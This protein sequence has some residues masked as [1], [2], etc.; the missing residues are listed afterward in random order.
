MKKI[1]GLDIGT[2]S[3]GLAVIEEAENENEASKILLLASRIIPT[4]SEDSSL[5]EFNTGKPI[6]KNRVKGEDRSKRRNF[7][8]LKLG[9]KNLIKDLLEMGIWENADIAIGMQNQKY[10]NL[11]N[12]LV[13]Q[14]F[15]V[16]SESSYQKIEKEDFKIL[17]LVFYN[18][19]V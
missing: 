2:N 11:K 1:L 19:V 15:R 8:R 16:R 3:I 9:K 12:I 18:E 17:G 13:E 10:P 4:K 5:T 6:S 7:A 14:I